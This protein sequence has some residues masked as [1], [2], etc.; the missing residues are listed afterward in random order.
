MSPRAL[1]HAQELQAIAEEGSRRACLL[2]IVQRTD[3]DRLRLTTQDAQ[4]REAVR[5]A[6]S[7]GVKVKAFAVRWDGPRAYLHRE[8]PLDWDE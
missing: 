8:L 2:F 3:C 4:Y 1:K 6:I 5:E 7:K